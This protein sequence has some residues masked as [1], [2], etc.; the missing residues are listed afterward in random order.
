M[1]IFNEFMMLCQSYIMFAFTDFFD[2][3]G[4]EETK[5]NL[6]WVVSGLLITQIAVN[7]AIIIY[8]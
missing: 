3:E 4:N 2:A 5:L 6:G 7:S 8:G 1:E